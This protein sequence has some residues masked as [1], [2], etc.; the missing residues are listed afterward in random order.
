[1]LTFLDGLM[2]VRELDGSMDDGSIT[3]KPITYDTVLLADCYQF[4]IAIKI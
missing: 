2:A 3:H 4:S 1:M